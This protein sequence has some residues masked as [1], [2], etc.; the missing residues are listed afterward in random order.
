MAL[1]LRLANDLMILGSINNTV[2]SD[3]PAQIFF[4]PDRLAL[5][6]DTGCEVQVPDVVVSG[7]DLLHCELLAGPNVRHANSGHWLAIPV[8]ELHQH[9]V[10]RAGV[11][12]HDA[13]VS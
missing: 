9:V 7:L 4:Y 13:H 12:G 6:D 8:V 11:V 10:K 5:L 3:G 1:E 2:Q